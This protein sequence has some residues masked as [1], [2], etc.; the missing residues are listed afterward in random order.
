MV[1]ESQDSECF[2][3]DFKTLRWLHRHYSKGT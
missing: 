2:Y 3:L 1:V